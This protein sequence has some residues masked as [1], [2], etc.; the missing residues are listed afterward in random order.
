[1]RIDLSGAVALVTG[2]CGGIG[3]AVARSLGA[4]GARVAVSDLASAHAESGDWRQYAHDVSSREQW[5]DVVDRLER[6][7]GQIDILCNAAGISHPLLEVEEIAPETWSKTLAVNATGVFFG[8]QAV[9][10]GMKRRRRGKIVNI[11]S[12]V[13]KDAVARNA[14]YGASKHAVIGLTQA[15]SREA[16]PHNI[17]VNAVCPGPVDTPLLNPS[18]DPAVRDK[19]QRDLSALASLGRIATVDDVAALVTFLVSEQARNVQ[20][21]AINVDAGRSTHT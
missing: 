4:A 21:Q 6:D 20:G 1:M 14:A 10:P 3:A 13:G 2:G 18:T 15:L 5:S 17:N 11:A 12:T 8:C 16:G 7:A 9:L 19:L